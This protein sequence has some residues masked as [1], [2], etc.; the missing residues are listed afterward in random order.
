MNRRN[1]LRDSSVVA[2][3]AVARS[4]APAS[5]GRT[6]RT[7]SPTA[8]SSPKIR[9]LTEQEVLDLILGSSIQA[10]RNSD[11]PG[12]IRRAKG[13]LAQGQPFRVVAHGDVPD[14]WNV[15]C[16]SGAIGGAGA[17]DHVSQRIRR[18]KLPAIAIEEGT[19]RAMD[20]LGRHLG[21]KW[22]AVISN[23]ASGGRIG[24]FVSATAR[25]LPVVDA[26][27]AL[28]CKPEVQIQMPTVMGVGNKPCAMV[29]RWG[30]QIVVERPADDYR[31]EDL[32]RAVSVASGGVCSIARTPLTGREVKIGTIP[33]ALTQAILFGRTV[34]EAV[35]RRQDPIAA[36]LRV[37]GG[38]LLFQGAVR[39]AEMTGLRGHTYWD[40]E[41]AG[42]GRFSGHIYTVWVKNENL[43]AWLDGQVDVMPPDLICNLDPRT[44]DAITG[45]ALGGY[46]IGERVAMVGIPAH[47]LWRQARGIEIFGPRH[48]GHDMDY[49]PIEELQARRPA[50]L[51]TR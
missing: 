40:V 34:R 26:C 50:A 3:A 51:R 30:D 27:L 17:W 46:R 23:E 43:L 5:T 16:A 1:F 29:T 28:R 19:L 33:D 38:T 31:V 37:A 36:L 12:M 9:I 39:K 21:V 41:I 4:S 32:G 48:F 24:A 22:D 42:E 10:T 18:Q 47:P 25:G 14:D 2:V 15:V 20:A 7:R 13:R 6:Q 11:T 35:E 45:A 8:T 44:G 49:V